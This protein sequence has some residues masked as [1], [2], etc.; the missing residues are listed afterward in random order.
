LIAHQAAQLAEHL[1]P[2]PFSPENKS[3]DGDHDDEQRRHREH[4]VVGKR[5]AHARRI[6][7]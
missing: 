3:G 5:R 4:A 6:V 1:A 2:R 7:V